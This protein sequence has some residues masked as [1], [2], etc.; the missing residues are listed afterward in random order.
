MPRIHPSVFAKA[1]A[2]NKSLVPLIPVCRDLGSARNELRWL[3]EHAVSV[4][5]QLGHG[6]HET[7]VDGYLRRR[8]RGE[9]LQYILGT[10]FFG[11]LEIRCRPGVLIPRQETAAS[12]SHLANLLASD[13]TLTNES[14]STLRVLDLC[15]GTGCIP[16]L[17]HHE[18]YTSNASTSTT[19]ELV[20]VDISTS[21][22]SVARE[23]LIHQIAHAA[24][25]QPT[26][27]SKRTRSLNQIGFVQADILASSP[28]TE[29]SGPLPLNEALGRLYSG[30]TE[31]PTFDILISNP[32][33]ISPSAYLRTTTRS[34]RNFEP[35]L[36]LVPPSPT[37]SSSGDD[38]TIGDAF[39]PHLWRLA[40][41]VKAKVCLFEVSDLQQAKRVAAMAVEHGKWDVVE[42]WRDE[43]G[44]RSEA[45]EELHVGGRSVGVRGAGN[46]RSVFARRGIKAE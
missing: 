31:P 29:S 38:E 36:A 7:I 22:L 28:S 12:I 27:H 46:G 1:R 19:L 23:N 34:V 2:I 26:A 15:T 45:V 25:A 14:N 33:Y 3:K 32:P 13:Q 44:A 39:Y 35:K 41:Q 37:P 24:R 20:G 16:L 11:N 6:E 18:L 30:E 5:K 40:E 43:P 21:A 42:I 17:F 4:S 10:E 9:P 8:A